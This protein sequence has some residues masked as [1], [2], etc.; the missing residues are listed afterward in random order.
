MYIYRG[1]Y[2]ILN[3]C[4][5]EGWVQVPRKN[6]LCAPCFVCL[7][8]FIAR[9]RGRGRPWLGLGWV[10]RTPLDALEL[11]SRKGGLLKHNRG[12]LTWRRRNGCWP[13]QS[14]TPPQTANA[15]APTEND[16]VWTAA[17]PPSWQTL[18]LSTDLFSRNWS[19]RYFTHCN[20]LCLTKTNRII[21]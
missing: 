19:S 8:A 17:F 14:K 4:G 7:G 16:S 1:A 11:R 20:R 18:S 5:G 9:A 15:H 6:F 12:S 3:L 2:K 10:P 21:C 13:S